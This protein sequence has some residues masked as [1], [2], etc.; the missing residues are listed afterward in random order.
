[1]TLNDKAFPPWLSKQLNAIKLPGDS[2]VF[3]ISES[4]AIRHTVQVKK[5]I[6]WLKVLHCRS[7][8]DHF[9][10]HPQSMDIMRELSADYLKIDR[11]FMHNLS[12]NKENRDKVKSIVGTAHSLNKLTIAEF[13]QDANCLSVLWQCGVDYIQG[14]FLQEPHERLDYDFSGEMV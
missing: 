7:A 12:S 14:Y 5:F 2:V 9:G 3:E 4:M 10:T 1:M 8:L 11:S 13:V 6:N